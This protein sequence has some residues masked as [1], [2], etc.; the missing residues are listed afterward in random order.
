MA[1]FGYLKL[2]HAPSFKD[3]AMIKPNAAIAAAAPKNT[4]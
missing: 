1:S 3:A 2:R 4:P